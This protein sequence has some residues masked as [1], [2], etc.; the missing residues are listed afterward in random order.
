MWSRMT[1][2]ALVLGGSALTA[3]LTL[4]AF[5][6]P[7][8]ALLAAG[9]LLV[10]PAWCHALALAS[11]EDDFADASR[12]RS[13]WLAILPWTWVLAPLVLPNLILLVTFFRDSRAD[14]GRSVLSWDRMRP[15]DSA[16]DH[17][18]PE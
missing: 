12:S 1:R 5:E 10:G 4:A 7:A 16:H 13:R 14:G 2:I 8:D 17:H 11:D 9:F 6:R 18:W 3:A 15:G